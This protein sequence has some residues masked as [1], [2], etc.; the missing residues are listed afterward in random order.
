MRGQRTTTRALLL[1]LLFAASSADALT[2][3]STPRLDI[4]DN[5]GDTNPVLD[6]IDTTPYFTTER[7]LSVYIDFVSA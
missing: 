2:I 7:V 6:S 4:A 3:S 1:T 5:A